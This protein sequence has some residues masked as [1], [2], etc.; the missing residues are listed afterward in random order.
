MRE[1]SFRVRSLGSAKPAVPAAEELGDWIRRHAGTAADLTTWEVEETLRSQ[2]SEVWFPAAGGIW[3]RDR[4][5]AAFPNVS[6]QRISGEFDL[7]AAD[8]SA[9]CMIAAGIRKGCWWAV[10]SPQALHL[11][12]GYFA[13]EDT[14]SEAVTDA[15]TRVCRVMRDTGATGHVLVYDG[16]PDA[17]D[18]EH[19]SGKRFLRYVPDAF[20]EIVLEVQRDLILSAD[21][22]PR[23]AELSDCYTIRQVYVTGPT[24]EA[25]AE[26]C[27]L[28]DPDNVFC[29][30][31]APEVE[32]EEYWKNLAEL[33]VHIRNV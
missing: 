29:A 8:I 5:L 18:Q 10:P 20:L 24:T 14:A 6:E 32:Q 15:V 31:T 19:F 13:D 21:A 27:R 7:H 33:R 11:T 16:V 1:R 30:G 4:I 2:G 22:V 26:V 25:L 3:Y 9:D 17:V 28:F 23:L 12:D